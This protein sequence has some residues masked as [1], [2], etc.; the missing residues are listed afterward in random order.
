MHALR[1]NDRLAINKLV[2]QLTRSAVRS[3]M[4]Q[5]LLVRYVAQVGA[6]ESQ[7]G[8]GRRSAAQHGGWLCGGRVGGWVVAGGA[9]AGAGLR[10]LTCCAFLQQIGQSGTGF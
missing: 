9:G 8:T 1:A 7:R 10:S 5:C 4:A 2:S 3:P 6:G